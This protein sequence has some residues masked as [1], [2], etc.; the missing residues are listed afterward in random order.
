MCEAGLQIPVHSQLVLRGQ[1]AGRRATL[2]YLA[3]GNPCTLPLSMLWSK[4]W[5]WGT[6]TR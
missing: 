5:C 4:L 3:A 1:V 2:V 6:W